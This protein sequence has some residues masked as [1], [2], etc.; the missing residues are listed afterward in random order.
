MDKKVITEA[1]KLI[2]GFLKN[3]R[4]ELG[5]TQEEL[6]EL[7]GVKRLTIIRIETNKFLPNLELFLTL[8]HHLKCYFYLAEKEGDKPDAVWMRE[9]WGKESKN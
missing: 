2:S 8:T 7:C 6:A 3:R 5:L 1:G 4:E 9:R